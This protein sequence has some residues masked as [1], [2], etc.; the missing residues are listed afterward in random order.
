MAFKDPKQIEAHT[1]QCIQSLLNVIRDQIDSI[2]DYVEST[3]MQKKVK[4]ELR[5]VRKELR[6]LIDE[7]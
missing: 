2:P 3:E 6:K 7:N 5:I 4:K 1:Y